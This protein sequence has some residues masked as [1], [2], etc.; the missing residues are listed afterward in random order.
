MASILNVS[1]SSIFGH[2]QVVTGY[3]LI[4]LIMK[5]HHTTDSMH[6]ALQVYVATYLLTT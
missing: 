4:D 2:V 5:I 1:L 3:A 6:N